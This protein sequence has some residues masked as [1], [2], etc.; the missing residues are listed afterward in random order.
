MVMKCFLFSFAIRFLLRNIFAS[1]VMWLGYQFGFHRQTVSG[2][3]DRFG[4][5]GYSDDASPTTPAWRGK[6]LSWRWRRR[7]RKR[8]MH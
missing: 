4:H 1:V 7:P 2:L 8:W 3:L 6:M 5:C